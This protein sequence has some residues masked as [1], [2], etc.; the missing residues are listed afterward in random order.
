MVLRQPHRKKELLLQKAVKSRS[1]TGPALVVV[2]LRMEPAYYGG[3][4][5]KKGV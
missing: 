3:Q 2:T 4:S 1:E 5:Q